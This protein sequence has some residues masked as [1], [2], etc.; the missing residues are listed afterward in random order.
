MVL[1]S[2]PCLRSIT[3]SEPLEKAAR[4]KRSR[5]GVVCHVIE[6]SRDA[7]PFNRTA[8]A[9]QRDRA[10]KPGYDSRGRPLL[11]HRRAAAKRDR[12]AG[13]QG[14]LPRVIHAQLLQARI[15]SR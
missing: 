7:V 2:F 4:N 8:D 11:R 5:G 3:S 1:M 14:K 10:G 15:R 6:A 9:G 13:E 12:D